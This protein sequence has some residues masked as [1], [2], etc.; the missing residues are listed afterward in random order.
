MSPSTERRLVGV[1]LPRTT[2]WR[3]D[4]NAALTKRAERQGVIRS[5]IN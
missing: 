1:A 4:Y 2:D 3:F 5:P